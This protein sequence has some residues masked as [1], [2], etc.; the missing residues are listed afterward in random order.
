[1][2]NRQENYIRIIAGIMIVSGT[3]LA[4]LVSQWWL[5]LPAFI[6][7]N[8]FQYG[9]TDFCPMKIILRKLGIKE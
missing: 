3:I 7:L 5:I 9:F 6:G 2:E 1:M 4:Y 8:L